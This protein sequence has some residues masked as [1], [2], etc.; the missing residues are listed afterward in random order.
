MRRTTATIV[1]MNRVK[2]P[3]VL[4]EDE[5]GYYVAEVPIIPGCT[6]HGK[7]MAEAMANIRQAAEQCLANR[8][9]EGWELPVSYQIAQIEVSL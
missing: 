1:P 5:D 8:E 9:A 6:A 2:I 3:V 7:T 4:R